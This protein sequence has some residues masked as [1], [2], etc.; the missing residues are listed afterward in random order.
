MCTTSRALFIFGNSPCFQCRAENPSLTLVAP[1]AQPY[2]SC[3]LPVDVRV[4]TLPPYARAPHSPFCNTLSLVRHMWRDRRILTGGH[5]EEVGCDGGQ[6][7]PA[8]Q[9]CHRLT[10]CASTGAC[11]SARSVTLAAIGP[12]QK[13]AT[14]VGCGCNIQGGGAGLHTR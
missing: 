3:S 4:P 5:R 9:G 13:A 8:R 11:F 14:R 7:I 10:R 2:S 6:S 1:P 12:C